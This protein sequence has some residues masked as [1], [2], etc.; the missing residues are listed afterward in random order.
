MI[1]RH[2]PVPG[3]AFDGE[4]EAVGPG[5]FPDQPPDLLG[6][7]VIVEAAMADGRPARQIPDDAQEP[8][9]AAARDAEIARSQA[10]PERLVFGADRRDDVVLAAKPGEEELDAGAANL[11]GFYEDETARVGYD[12]VPATG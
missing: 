2:L 5:L 1:E 9:F 10:L 4:F 12:H 11:V 7:D 8:P 6:R 3:V